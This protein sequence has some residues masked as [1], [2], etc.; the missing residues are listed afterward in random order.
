MRRLLESMKVKVKKLYPDAKL[1]TK[2]TP[3]SA[4]YDVYTQAH[5]FLDT[6]NRVKAPTGLAFELP[7]DVGMDIRPRSGLASRGFLI[8]NSP[9]TL[10]SDYRG[11][12]L[13]SIMNISGSPWHIEKGERIAQIR[14]FP[15]LEVEWEEVEELS[16]TER[17]SDGF[18]STG[19]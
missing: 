14:L 3:G 13:I 2:A 15:I 16:E 5:L 11:E 9:G 17:G 1:P 19:K 12:L 8:L 4:C 6:W 7:R 18:G 10:D